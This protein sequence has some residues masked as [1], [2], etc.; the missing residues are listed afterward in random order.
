M[1]LYRGRKKMDPAI[2]REFESEKE[3][4]N[5]WKHI[6]FM[7]HQQREDCRKHACSIVWEE[8]EVKATDSIASELREKAKDMNHHIQDR[9]SREEVMRDKV[10][11]EVAE[12][13]FKSYF[14]HGLLKEEGEGVKTL[15]EIRQATELSQPEERELAR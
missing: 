15:K 9:N 3:F 12:A 8:A 5:A 14:K 11:K 4:C 2:W 1:G 6:V 7:S 13:L 10:D